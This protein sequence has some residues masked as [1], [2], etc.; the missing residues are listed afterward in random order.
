MQIGELSER[1]GVSRRSIRYYEQKGLLHAH[2]TGKGWREY[3]EA[4]VNRVRNVRELLQAG[5]TVDDIQRVA[6]CLGM[7]MAAFMACRD[8]DHAISMYE[9][10]LAVI[11][12]KMAVLEQHRQELLRRIAT[13]RQ[14][15][16]DAGLAE[17]LR[18][19]QDA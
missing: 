5:L 3:D 15:S 9:E 1:T 11:D 18:H 17:L 12:D 7:D 16:A 14:N 13:L 10:R 4:A 6:P 2:R 8:A 19:A